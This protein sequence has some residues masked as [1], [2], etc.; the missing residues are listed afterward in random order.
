MAER[1]VEEDTETSASERPKLTRSYTLVV[2]Q[3]RNES[4][5]KL[6]EDPYSGEDP[7]R[8]SMKDTR[9]ASMQGQSAPRT[10]GFSVVLPPVE[11]GQAM[12]ATIGR[13]VQR[14]N[15]RKHVLYEG[16]YRVLNFALIAIIT[17]IITGIVFVSTWHEAI[18]HDV[19]WPLFL[20]VAIFIVSV[21]LVIGYVKIYFWSKRY[22]VGYRCD[23]LL[24]RTRRKTTDKKGRADSIESGATGSKK[25]KK[26]SVTLSS[27][28]L[29][30]GDIEMTIAQ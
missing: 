3:T 14:E 15:L 27:A 1:I 29:E 10:R 20:G 7:R 23:H 11:E 26:T 25:V 24:K 5:Y 16:D 13:K 28:I 12:G 17:L 2:H 8:G 18:D 30:D 22:G 6:F 21:S 4:V 9:R 19:N